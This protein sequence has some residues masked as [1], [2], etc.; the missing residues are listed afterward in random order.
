MCGKPIWRSSPKIEHLSYSDASIVGWAGFVVQFGLHIA[1]RNWLGSAALCSSSFIE[2]RFPVFWWVRSASIDL[3]I[4]AS[5]VSCLSAVVSLICKKKWLPFTICATR[6]VFAFLWSGHLATLISK[7]II[8]QKLLTP[9]TGC[10]TRSFSPVGYSVG[11]PHRR[12][13]CES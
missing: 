4:R 6:Q 7:L 1:R 8:G 13:F 2:I 3:T 5:V 10:S 12:L 11:T 9:M